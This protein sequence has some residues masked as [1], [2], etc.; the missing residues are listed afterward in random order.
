VVIAIFGIGPVYIELA[1]RRSGVRAVR[2]TNPPAGTGTAFLGSKSSPL[3]THHVPDNTKM[4]CKQR[5]R[6][7][8][9]EAAV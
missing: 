1:D 2:L 5:C 8:R 9:D 6:S 7:L 4:R 3:F